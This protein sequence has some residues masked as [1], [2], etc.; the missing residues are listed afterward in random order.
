SQGYLIIPFLYTQADGNPI[1]S[2]ALLSEQGHKNHLHQTENPAKL[3]SSNLEEILLIAKKHL[4]ECEENFSK[5]DYFQQRYTYQNNLIIIHQ[6]T[7][8][9]FYDH[10]PPNELKNIAAPK[11]FSNPSECINWVKQGLDK[12][13]VI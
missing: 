8:K 12:N 11:L 3:Y 4:H 13:R 9:C 5:I 1:Y 10:Y 6:E 7:G 2:Y